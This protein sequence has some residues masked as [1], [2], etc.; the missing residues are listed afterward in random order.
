MRIKYY[1][2]LNL[3]FV[4]LL[5]CKL[6]AQSPADTTD[7]QL[8]LKQCVDFALKNQP[9][10]RQAAIDEAINEK[11]IAI[12]LSAW[13]P[14]VSSTGV[15]DYYFKGSPITAV[16]TNPSATSSPA[17]TTSNIDNL[18]TLGLQANQVIYNNEVLQAAK[19]A[20]YS[21]QYYKQNTFSSQVNVVS[22]VSKA[23]FD[24]LLSEKQL[25]ILN[26]DIKRLQRSLKDAYTQYKA[27]TVDKTDYKQAT[28]NLNNSIA[29]RK[30]T[31][32]AIKS[33][34]AYLKQI[35]GLNAN[36]KFTLVYDSTR[37]E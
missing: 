13:L 22:D 25:D 15:Y 29:S 5:P 18:S 21:R 9:A 35:M 1:L 6:F 12:N 11:D 31:E 7:K 28:I 24:V 8:T 36:G 34:L 32:E 20:K 4:I 10:V 14:Q 2:F 26:E 23:F 30:Q 3:I 16:G 37:Y 33:K 19:A 17:S 27:G